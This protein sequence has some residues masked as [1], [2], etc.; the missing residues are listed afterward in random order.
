[1]VDLLEPALL[2]ETLAYEAIQME[3]L[4]PVTCENRLIPLRKERGMARSPKLLVSWW[5]EVSVR[6]A[7]S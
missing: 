7:T 5:W 6:P 1:M 3:R 4:V 2:W